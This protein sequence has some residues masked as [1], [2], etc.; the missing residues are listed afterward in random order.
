MSDYFAQL[1]Y[2]L[3]NEDTA[4]ELG[5]LEESV[6]H[7]CAIA[8]SGGRVLPLFAKNPR[9]MT[10]VDISPIQL[11]LTELRVETAR[12]LEH[13]E[14]LAFWGYPPG[15][16]TSPDERQALFAKLELRP[17]LA[18]FW[19]EWFAAHGWECMLYEGRWEKTFV[20][21]SKTVG[22]VLGRGAE[23]LFQAKSSQEFATYL[24]ERFPYRR[25]LL[26]LLFLGNATVFNALLYKSSFPKKNL[27]ETFF[28]F[29]RRCFDRLFTLGPA[30]ESFFLQ[31][32]MLGELR[33]PEGNPLECQPEL[34][35]KVK[36]GIQ[37]A[38][39]EFLEADLTSSEVVLAEP[40]DFLSFSDV[41]SYFSGE[42]E[43]EYLQRL[44][45][46]LAD[47]GVVVLRYYIHVP[48]G[49][50]KQ[51]FTDLSE[52]YRELTAR[53]RVGVYKF[54]VLRRT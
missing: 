26:C 17:E 32:L 21:L 45:D 25:W 19:R 8:G 6:G 11:K 13:E 4:V 24:K 38:Q 18:A 40:I 3:A 46:R 36:E 53:E 34:F 37:G 10:C 49:T 5:V 23:D 48:E 35:A 14:F 51:G 44:R 12:H 9:R 28:G 29:Y 2:T 30:R 20:R 42:L 50:R 41:A 7:V 16:E 43:R 22:R 27:P 54:D 47:G 15:Q 39:I 33:Y 31:L 1:N 52:D